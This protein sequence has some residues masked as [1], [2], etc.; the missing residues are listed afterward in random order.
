VKTGDFSFNLPEELIAQEPARPRDASRLLSLSRTSGQL[1]DLTFAQLPTLLNPGDLLVVND[2]RVIPARLL[3]RKPTGG[4]VEVLLLTRESP[5]DWEALVR[6]SKRSRVGTR[7]VLDEDVEL[8]VTRVLGD[9]RYAVRL[10]CAED[11][12]AAVER[13]GGIPLPPYIR[14][15]KMCE[16]D[17]EWYQTVYA[18]PEKRGS[19]AAP[20][21]GLHFTDDIFGELDKKGIER[22]AVTLHVGLGTFLPVRVDEVTDHKMHS[23]R[24]HVEAGVAGKINRA[25]DEGRRVVAVGT[26]A[27]RVLEH[28]GRS[29]RVV[30]GEGSTEIFIYPGFEFKVVGAMVT[31]FHLPESTLL[32]LISAFCGKEAVLNAYRHAVKERYRFYSYGDAMFIG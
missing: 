27:T 31:N 26:T 20:T 1:E 6:A 5:R 8:E 4:Q 32:M 28:C 19:A 13:L 9:G 24:Y 23:E 7:I 3:G 16:A 21:A 22:V 2:T 10:H 30:P 15:G 25:L 14:E 17:R 11:P 18:H 29:G 12:D